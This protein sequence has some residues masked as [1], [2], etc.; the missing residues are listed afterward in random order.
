M[1]SIGADLLE[2][3][4]TVRR[5]GDFCTSGRIELLA[6]SL[7]V[8]GVGPVALP[9]LPVQAAQLAA[10]AEQAPYGRGADTLVDTDV[11]RTWQ[12]GPDK[13]RVT[14]RHW[15][16][17]LEAI[18]ARVA[19]GL[20]VSDPVE[21]E[22]YKMLLYDTGSFFVS[23]RDTEKSPGMFATLV[24]VLP[25]Q[26]EGG[27]LVVRHQ[28]RESRFDMRC[29]DPA[30][31][32]FAAF[33]ADCL[34]EVL[35]VTAGCR[36]T[37]V[38][39]VLRRGRGKVPG[40][41]DYSGEQIRAAELLQ[42]W[43]DSAADPEADEPLKLVHL[44]EHAYTP[45]ELG[46]DALKGADAAAAGVLAAA[47][48][49]SGCDL[50][51]ALL[52]R[53]ESGSAEYNGSYRR[54]RRYSDDDDDDDEFEVGEIFDSSVLLSEWRTLDGSPATLGEIP[55][56]EEEITLADAF[57]NLKPDEIHF[58]EA[59]GNAG[60]SFE[61]TY[62][63][64]ALVLWPHDSTF[65]VLCQAGLAATLP[66]LEDMARRWTADGADFA[67]PLRR[68][69]HDLAGHMIDQWPKQHGYPRR[70][71]AP[72]EA[73]RMLAALTMLEDIASIE[74]FLTDVTAGGV[75]AK[76]DNAAVLDALGL[77]PSQTG[78][79]LIE[80]IVRATGATAFAACADLLARA[81]APA[82]QVATRLR[83]A[84]AALVDVL[85]AGTERAEFWEQPR[86]HVEAGFV[87]DLQTALAAIDET[88]A[89][90]A[91]THIL[92]LPNT[93]DPDTVLVPAA[94]LM[95]GLVSRSVAAGRLHAACLA[96]LRGRI[97]K[98]L[99]P[100]ADWRRPSV[101]GCQCEYC[102]ELSRFLADPARGTWV[103]RAHQTHR[104]HVEGTIQTAHCDVDTATERRGSPHSL[105]CTKNQAS[106][107]R[108]A[109]QRAEDIANVE[110][111]AR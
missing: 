111:L 40:P 93:Y 52:T 82:P 95:R 43:R 5:P 42:E 84:A 69:A 8:A 7:A 15:P 87:V 61:R 35:P 9:L 6:P 39:N 107:E 22:F 17:T 37:L 105:I 94:K 97:A 11:R 75:Y 10:V 28:G 67:A 106:Y 55:V 27:E 103:L 56:E 65:A 41:P 1:T 78:I 57:E 23:H 14:G 88:L 21:A 91:V 80:R 81:A 16:R 50:H 24:I 32:S 36:L 85:P 102:S 73:M 64:A 48:Q 76:A 19:E 58:E 59:T 79:G 53:E 33:Y 18:L 89:D 45:A 47:A 83:D 26:C 86:R 30:E 77:M 4:G 12:I 46:F 68:D 13:V 31:A 71:D 72:T 3:L 29:D 100:P 99:A 34:H 70:D 66:Y 49:Q 2:L 25:S 51:L 38:Y 74:T 92:A 104:S 63:R 44:L 109:R 98:P 96:H 110:V 60:A 101:V 90:R 62:R 20:G 108:L 54:G